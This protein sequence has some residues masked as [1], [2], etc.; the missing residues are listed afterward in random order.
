MQDSRRISLACVIVAGLN[1]P[2]CSDRQDNVLAPQ[3]AAVPP[4]VSE[5]VDTV[6]QVDVVTDKPEK[7]EAAPTVE[8]A[9]TR[10]PL[11]LSMPPQPVLAP[12]S[13][14]STNATSD[15]LLPDLFEKQLDDGRSMRFKGRALMSGGEEQNIDS[16]EG[17]QVIFESETR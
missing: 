14:D 8:K 10:K 4:P 11:D 1:L 2:G 3:T 9:T 15:H 13:V 5:P 6:I 16:L 17:G 12:D 7:R